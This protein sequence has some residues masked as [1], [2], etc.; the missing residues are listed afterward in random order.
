VF[1]RRF[2]SLVNCLCGAFALA[3]RFARAKPPYTYAIISVDF[4]IDE[5]MFYA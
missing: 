3:W 1:I 2:L 4:S 5:D